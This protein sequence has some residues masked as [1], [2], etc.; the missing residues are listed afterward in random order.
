MPMPQQYQRVGEAFDAFLRDARDELGHATRNQ[1]YTTVEGVLL[2]FRRR[3]TV[4]QGLRFADALPAV[5]RA[6]F[7]AGWDRGGPTVPLGSREAMTAEVKALR[8][9]HNF[10]PDTAIRDV[11][12]ALA[13][14]VDAPA[15][16]AAMVTLPEEAQ[17]FW[18]TEK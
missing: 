6:M 10:A 2:A 11:A 1:T 13:K 5:L 12:R 3:L 17:A 15:F 16:E 9:G 7:V 18:N 14:H 4:Q 8:S